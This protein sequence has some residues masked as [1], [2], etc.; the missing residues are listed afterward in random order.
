MHVRTKVD[1]A[2]NI[3]SLCRQKIFTI[4]TRLTIRAV[5][6][7][8]SAKQRA[9]SSQSLPYHEFW[10][11]LKAAEA[12]ADNDVHLKCIR[13][14]PNVGPADSATPHKAANWAALQPLWPQAAMLPVAAPA[15]HLPAVQGR[16]AAK[17]DLSYDN[18]CPTTHTHHSLSSVRC[19]ERGLTSATPSYLLVGMDT[20]W[21]LLHT[22]LFPYITFH[23]CT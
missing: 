20:I 21:Y 6:T 9:S 5:S 4:H 7:Q 10:A 17:L 8:P 1:K 15:R 18:V 3:L 23:I 2:T 13:K 16:Q 19:V 22:T 11:P 14:Y 12:R